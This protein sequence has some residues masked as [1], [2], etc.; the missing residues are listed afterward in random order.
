MKTTMKAVVSVTCGLMV[1]AI[2]ACGGGGSQ[3]PQLE[4]LEDGAGSDAIDD[5]ESD[6]T[7]TADVDEISADAE[8]PD[9]QPDGES[10]PDVVTDTYEAFVPFDV[11]A[12]A[13]LAF[14]W[15]NPNEVEIAPPEMVT[16]PHL[17]NPNGRLAGSFANVF[18]CLNEPGGISTTQMAMGQMITISLCVLEQTVAPDVDGNYLSVQ[19]PEDMGD[20]ND[21]FSEVQMYYHV[22]RVH[23]Y[24]KDTIGTTTM[25][26]PLRALVNVQGGLN[27]GGITSWIAIDNAAFIPKE[28]L[29]QLADMVSVEL[30]FD[31]DVMLFGQGS[32]IDF[33]Y[34]G[35]VVYHEYTHAVVGGDRLWASR[36]DTWGVDVAPLSLNEALADYFPA[37]FT[38]DPVT[39][40]WSLGKLDAARDLS[41]AATCPA[42]VV[43]ESHYDGVVASSALWAIRALLGAPT[44]DRI[45]FDVMSGSVQDTNFEEFATALIAE[46]ALL[47]PPKDAEVEAILA[48]HGML[49]CDR[50]RNLADFGPGDITFVPGLQTTGL[51]EFTSRI[52]GHN[53]FRFEVPENTV[54][55][56]LTWE[57]ASSQTM[58]ML[59]SL[60]GE[61]SDVE[62]D[63]ALKQGG[64]PILWSY[65]S[66]GTT[67]DSDA[68]VLVTR[69][70]KKYA[71]TV[72]GTCLVPGTHVMQFLVKSDMSG[73]MKNLS[74]TYLTEAPV[75]GASVRTYD[76]TP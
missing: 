63:L 28:S 10:D 67:N 35:D 65:G 24:F 5:V 54:A 75:A 39:G 21:P 55:V 70:N 3:G 16:L 33:A 52:P 40:R 69:T 46:A 26:R 13:N 32:D 57:A 53:Q 31:E 6:T 68:T 29:E 58:D 8:D 61:A 51:T 49:G 23:D 34:D 62:M 9:A 20:P 45:V 36:A 50:V 11:P 1:L 71:V 27:M 42:D 19:V 17:T 56:T 73:T 4:I 74:A 22:N 48:E 43:G 41:V 30:P 72:A 15:A 60:T 2:A 76:C 59:A 66:R 38:D 37:T 64:D 18:N 47:D 7:S 44:T 14:V 12:E 25:D